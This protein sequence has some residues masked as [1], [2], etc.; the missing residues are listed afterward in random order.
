MRVSSTDK[1]Y[2]HNWYIDDFYVH[3]M[4][5][6]ER[7]T[8]FKE[9]LLEILSNESTIQSKDE[10]QRLIDKILLRVPQYES[11]TY[12]LRYNDKFLLQNIHKQLAYLLIVHPTFLQNHPLFFW[13]QQEIVKII[14]NKIWPIAEYENRIQNVQQYMYRVKGFSDLKNNTSLLDKMKMLYDSPYFLSNSLHEIILVDM[15]AKDFFPNC[16]VRIASNVDDRKYWFDAIVMSPYKKFCFIDFTFKEDIVWLNDK[17]NRMNALGNSK[18]KL[19]NSEFAI[20]AYDNL[21]ISLAGHQ[22]M[23]VVFQVNKSIFE[24]KWLPSY[25]HYVFPWNNDRMHA[26]KFIHCDE[27]DKLKKFMR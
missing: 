4:Q 2:E 19:Y 26:D 3:C 16:S 7:T 1:N 17:I 23:W 13:I 27:M 10:F 5:S 21:N 20:F 24:K 25:L 11:Y 6:I 14:S 8:L 18:N 15:I 12:F 9:R 22:K